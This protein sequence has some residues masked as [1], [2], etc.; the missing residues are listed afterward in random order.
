MLVT[1]RDR[2]L[3]VVVVVR[4]IVA[5]RPVCMCERMIMLGAVQ[6]GLGLVAT[7]SGGG[8]LPAAEDLPHPE[9]TYRQP[10]ENGTRS[11]PKRDE[12]APEHRAE[13]HGRP[14]ADIGHLATDFGEL[15]WFFADVSV[16]V[17]LDVHPVAVPIAVEL[18]LK[19]GN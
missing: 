12:G 15:R 9:H 2:M 1:R 4:W 6:Q 8:S 17:R 5:Q 14:V 18:D 11:R 13:D 16:F 7:R 3:V 19:R 10:P